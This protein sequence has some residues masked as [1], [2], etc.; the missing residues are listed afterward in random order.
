M[1][2]YKLTMSSSKGSEAIAKLNQ[3]SPEVQDTYKDLVRGIKVTL[4]EE[5]FQ[6]ILT[7]TPSANQV[8]GDAMLRRPL[9]GEEQCAY[10]LDLLKFQIFLC[11][12]YKNTVYIRNFLNSLLRR[13]LFN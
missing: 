6:G 5:S 12:G 13:L 11:N 3:D 7:L 1:S 8:D 10:Y 2:C 4:F 9:N